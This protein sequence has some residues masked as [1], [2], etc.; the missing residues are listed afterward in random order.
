MTTTEQTPVVV[1]GADGSNESL[2]AVDWAQRYAEATGASLRV[3]VAY[4]WPQSYGYPMM[5]EGFD[6]ASD[7]KRVA[8]KVS[9]GLTLPADRTS[10]RVVEG[11]PGE[12]LVAES[13]DADVLVVGARGHSKIERL[14]LGSVSTYC[15]HHSTVPVAV[16]R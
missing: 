15:V 1:V 6:P 11:T 4:L 8:E 7:A 12:V 13:A 2:V 3:V 10:T 9:A 5:F 16:V 14:T